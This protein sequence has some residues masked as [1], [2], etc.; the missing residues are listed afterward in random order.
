[1]QFKRFCQID[2]NGT[3]ELEEPEFA[4]FLKSHRNL[5]F[6]SATEARSVFQIL[7]PLHR[8]VVTYK[9]L[10]RAVFPVMDVAD[11]LA[12]T[13]NTQRE[14]EDAPGSYCANE[15]I[16]SPLPG[17]PPQTTAV[18]TSAG[19]FYV[20]KGAAAVKDELVQLKARVGKLQA[21]QEDVLAQ[22]A[23]L[24]IG[25]K[26]MLAHLDKVLAGLELR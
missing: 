2:T 1:M 4:T 20:E 15:G 10:A 9:E 17:R 23:K 21:G 25:Q 11:A 6:M 8:G 26:D 12:T 19:A 18:S 22:V 5:A 7:D 3:N 13:W 14:E 16:A 24:Q